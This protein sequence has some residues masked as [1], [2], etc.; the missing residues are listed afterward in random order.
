M[1]STDECER[2]RLCVLLDRV[3]GAELGEVFEEVERRGGNDDRQTDERDQRVGA[4]VGSG[5]G[6]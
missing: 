6:A 1:L 4:P 3:E 5:C 2:T